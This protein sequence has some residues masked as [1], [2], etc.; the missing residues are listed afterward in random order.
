LVCGL[1][2]GGLLMVRIFSA[3]S[4]SPAV[5]DF[6]IVINFSSIDFTLP[7][8]AFCAGWLVVFTGVFE[9]SI[10]IIF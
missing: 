4:F 1:F 8:K 2:Y 10:M 7:I 5:A 6:A 9:S 3:S